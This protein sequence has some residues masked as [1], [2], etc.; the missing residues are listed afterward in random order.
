MMQDEE[1]EHFVPLLKLGC[2]LFV[3]VPGSLRDSAARDLQEAV[4]RRLSRERAITGLVIDV[5]ALAVV[6]SFVA[7][8]LGDIATIARTFG[9]RA[10][11]VGMRPGVATTLVDLG[12]D[13]AAVETALTLEAAL[14]RLKLRIVSEA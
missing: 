12:I 4:A 2:C 9:A 14:G 7:K 6:D 10:V 3:S 13:L 5:S 8:V 1:L 11:M